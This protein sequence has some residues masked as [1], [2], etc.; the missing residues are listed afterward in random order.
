M[1]GSIETRVETAAPFGLTV[2]KLTAFP[3]EVRSPKVMFPPNFVFR[4]SKSPA[5]VSLSVAD[6]AEELKVRRATDV[7][8]S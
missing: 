5:E 1:L 2:I 3:V 8:S 7:R 4:I 6:P